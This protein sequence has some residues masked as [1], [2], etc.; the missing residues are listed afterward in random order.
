MDTNFW[1][2]GNVS[3]LKCIKTHL[4]VIISGFT[5]HH[6]KH[7]WVNKDFKMSFETPFWWGPDP[8]IKMLL[9]K[10]K[11]KGETVRIQSSSTMLKT[12]NIKIK[13]TRIC[14]VLNV[15]RT[16]SYIKNIFLSI[17]R[18]WTTLDNCWRRSSTDAR[19]FTHGT[20][21][22]TKI[23]AITA[24]ISQRRRE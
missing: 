13:T 14:N 5:K 9:K 19:V 24:E 4:D 3:V 21:H 22:L 11:K 15:D 2:H 17:R 12:H 20:F 10:R 6:W 1:Q 18:T 8:W 23:Q 7:T 16:F